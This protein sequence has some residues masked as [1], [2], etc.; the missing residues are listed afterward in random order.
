MGEPAI[1]RALLSVSDKSGL[2]AFARFLH[3]RGVELLASG[4][5]HAAIKKVGLPVVEVSDYTQ[6]PEMLD[7]R[8]KTL[9]PRL[10]GG[11]LAIR[12]NA[13][14]QA[15]LAEHGILPID[16]VVVS[17]YPFEEALRT[18]GLSEDEIIEKID[19][20]GPSLIR[21]AAKNFKDVCVLVHPGQYDALIEQMRQHDGATTFAF[22]KDLAKQAFTRTA[23]FDA[24]VSRYFRKTEAILPEAYPIAL[25]K[26]M[27][28][29]YG[30]NPHQ[31]AAFYAFADAEGS[32]LSTVLQGKAISY[33]NIMDVHA[34]VTISQELEAKHTCVIIKHSNPCGVGVSSASLE[35]AY[36]RALA[37]DPVSAFGGI[38]A[39]NGTVSQGLAEKTNKLFTEIVVA[40]SF[41]EEARA[42]YKKKAN[43]RLI[44][45]DLLKARSHMRHRDIRRALDGYLI[46]DSDQSMENL[47]QA[48]VVTKRSPTP[49]EYRALDLAWR[50]VKHVKSN[51][52]VVANDVQTLG[53]GAG[54]MNRLASVKLATLQAQDKPKP[55][56]LASDAFFPFKDS[57]EEVQKTGITA[58]VQ[59]GGSIKD[60]E[61]IEAANKAGI[62]MVF[63]GIRHFNH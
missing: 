18:P 37:C 47:A 19:I 13:E 22:R 14:H 42:V 44:E 49:E 24:A 32:L 17:L 27:S 41:S 20:G 5:T 2:E 53:I 50:V 4:G 36:D 38:L 16:L 43:L 12:G 7:G 58:V 25:R 8:V 28:L 45:L 10:H 63:T 60:E 34:A 11:I 31:Q 40:A 9:H 46:Q 57:I 6:S 52:I 54:Q 26:S 3:E 30:E 15:Q 55:R 48:K 35:E 23:C 59:P 51:A 1:R 21:S 33:N 56:V 61:V 39:F 62:A 29:R